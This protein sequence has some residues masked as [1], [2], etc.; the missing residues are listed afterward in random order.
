MPVLKNQRHERFAQA[1]FE[2]KSASEAYVIAGYAYNEG[3]A[4]RLK[5]NEQVRERL[6]ELQGKAAERTEITVA[7]ISKKLLAIAQKAE[8][9]KQLNVARAAHMDVAKLNGL[10][11]DFVEHTGWE[12]TPLRVEARVITDQERARGLAALLAKARAK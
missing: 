5:G 2:G 8:N 6:D 1:L 7:G 12:E 9:S 11:K 3:N 10:L 4:C